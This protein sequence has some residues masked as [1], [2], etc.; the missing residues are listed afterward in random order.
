M[1]DGEV[2]SKWVLSCYLFSFVENFH[3]QFKGQYIELNS[4][5]GQKENYNSIEP[6]CTLTTFP[7][8]SYR[9]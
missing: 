6:G 4:S 8:L 1:G 2:G 5:I 9:L 3:L 7:P